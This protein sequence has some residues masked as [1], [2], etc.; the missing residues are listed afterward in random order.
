MFDKRSQ[1][2]NVLIGAFPCNVTWLKAYHNWLFCGVSPT[3]SRV[4][5]HPEMGVGINTLWPCDIISLNKYKIVPYLQHVCNQNVEETSHLW[6]RHFFGYLLRIPCKMSISFL[7]QS[8]HIF[9]IGPQWRKLSAPGINICIFSFREIHSLMESL[10]WF[11]RIWFKS[12][13]MISYMKLLSRMY[14]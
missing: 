11:D 10:P 14:C 2:F 12:D 8:W 5:S 9:S 1:A 7:N 6:L 4:T 13:F 3:W